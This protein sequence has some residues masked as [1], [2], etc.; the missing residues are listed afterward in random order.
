[1]NTSAKEF[2]PRV[3]RP[4]HCNYGPCQCAVQN[5]ELYCG[6]Y[7]RQAAALGIERDYCQCEHKNEE[8]KFFCSAGVA[9]AWT[10]SAKAEDIRGVYGKVDCT[11][12]TPS[13]ITY[14]CS[15]PDSQRL[16]V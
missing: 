11:E 5:N 8:I 1:M 13:G 9:P 7:C 14:S 10:A 2:A 3:A 16:S 4:L 6:E 12:G 15:G